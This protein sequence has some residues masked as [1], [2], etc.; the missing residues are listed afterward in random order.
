ME[1]VLPQTPKITLWHNPDCSK[2][3]RALEL[4]ELTECEVEL[5]D[6]LATPPTPDQLSQLLAWLG[7]GCEPLA[8][9]RLARKKEARW[10][11]LGLEGADDATVIAALS[12]NPAL[13][14]RP[15]AVAPEHGEALIGRPPERVLKLLIPKPPA[16]MNPEDMLRMA[17]Q[18]RLPK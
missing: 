15:I 4:L 1:L 5:F 9:H 12:A 18:G 16:G 8:A 10:N 7:S 14:E 3:R 6:Y 11:E 17:L 13:I 2:S